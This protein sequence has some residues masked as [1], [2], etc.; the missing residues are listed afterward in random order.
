MAKVLKAERPDIDKQRLDLLKLQ[1]EYQARLRELESILL[2]KIASVE[3]TILDNDKVISALET[4]KTEAKE[5]G[6]KSASAAEVM[7]SV[8]DVS[9]FYQPVA[10]ACS[11]MYFSIQE[12]GKIHYLYQFSLKIWHPILYLILC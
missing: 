8:N 12:L 11:I 6:E 7:K 4:L 2:Q 1:G 9:S 10:K 5:I 3:G